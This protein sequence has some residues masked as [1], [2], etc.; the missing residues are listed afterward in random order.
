MTQTAFFLVGA[1]ATGKSDLALRLA[2]RFAL[3]TIVSADSMN[4]YT[5]MDVGTS[6]PTAQ[7]RSEVRHVGMDIC[8]PDAH[9]SVGVWLEAVQTI[10][11]ANNNVDSRKPLIVAGGTGLYVSA[12]LHG[13]DDLPP[14]PAEVRAHW[15]AVGEGEGGLEALQTSLKNQSPAWF[16]ALDDRANRRRL[17]RALEL[18]AVGVTTPPDGWGLAHA[19]VAGLTGLRMQRPALYERINARAKQMFEEGLIEEAAALLQRYPCLSDTALKA[20]GYAEAFAAVRGDCSQPDAVEQTAIRTRR[21][22]KR[23]GTWFENQFDVDWVDVEQQSVDDIEDR[24]ANTWQS[25]G[26][27]ALPTL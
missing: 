8:T 19:R 11:A 2:R 23:Q 26:P 14:V 5:G 16:D 13:L 3:D 20:I 18:V 9:C 1:T 17:Q 24:V 6:K 4:V 21:L 10:C 7:A 22:A 12:L 25:V 27:V 15:Q